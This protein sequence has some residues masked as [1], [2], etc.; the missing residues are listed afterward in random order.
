MR[1]NLC[2]NH[3]SLPIGFSSPP[4]WPTAAPHTGHLVCF[5]WMER[6]NYTIM[7]IHGCLLGVASTSL[8]GSLS[9]TL[10]CSRF[11]CR[12]SVSQWHA[13][14]ELRR[15]EVGSWFGPDPQDGSRRRPWRNVISRH[16]A[17]SPRQPS[18]AA[19]SCSWSIAAF[20]VVLR[21]SP[22]FFTACNG[23]VQLSR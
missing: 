6:T 22:S 14:E 11:R 15:L 8:D 13:Q 5:V 12:K 17:S 4:T 23:F 1:G 20:M 9:V 19:H 18:S 7:Q 16:D 3:L 10:A 2:T 21:V